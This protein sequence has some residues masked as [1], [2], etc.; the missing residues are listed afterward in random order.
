[1]KR[2]LP[3]SRICGY[4]GRHREP[5]RT[6][7]PAWPAREAAADTGAVNG[8]FSLS[9]SSLPQRASRQ[10][11][12]PRW[13]A[14][15]RCGAWW[16]WRRAASGGRHSA[17]GGGG[18]SAAGGDDCGDPRAAPPLAP[19]TFA[20]T[21]ARRR[22][23]CVAG[24]ASST[25]DTT[26]IDGRRARIAGISRARH[27]PR[28]EHPR[29]T[30]HVDKSSSEALTAPARPDEKQKMSPCQPVA[31]FVRYRSFLGRRTDP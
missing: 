19:E 14:P 21:A 30:N 27:P 2:R 25:E 31:K 5:Q 22:R 9:A 17:R 24:F 3:Q 10:G 6:A 26:P 20:T 11:Y 15:P 18:R 8:Y 12:R 1:M 29:S 13:R 4:L 28:T 16:W 7:A 23:R